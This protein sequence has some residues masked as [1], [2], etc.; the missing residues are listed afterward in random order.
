[1][2]RRLLVEINFPFLIILLQEQVVI[3]EW[4]AK[5]LFKNCLRSSQMWWPS[6][7]RLTLAQHHSSLS[8]WPVFQR[9]NQK[10]LYI[11]PNLSAPVPRSSYRTKWCVQNFE[12]KRA[13]DS[14]FD[15]RESIAPSD[16]DAN[17]L[18]PLFN[19]KLLEIQKCTGSFASSKG[20]KL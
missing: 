3:S 9:S 8:A 12:E 2:L 5:Y 15:K 17:Q 7:K 10:N 18:L 1:M 13:A 16:L 20:S 6:D 19:K 11:K 14:V 4:K